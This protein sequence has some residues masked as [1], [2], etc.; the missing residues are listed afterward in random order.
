MFVCLSISNHVVNVSETYFAKAE[1]DCVEPICGYIS[2]AR[3]TLVLFGPVGFVDVAL[4][5]RA[6]LTG[7]KENKANRAS[8][9]MTEQISGRMKGSFSIPV[10]N[11][12]SAEA[13]FTDMDLFQSQHG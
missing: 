2:P 7:V 9:R 13:P 8:R 3:V 5:I 6:L 11:A 10:I 4:R 12:L 1:I